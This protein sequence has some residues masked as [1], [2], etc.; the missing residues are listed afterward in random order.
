MIGQMR[1]LLGLCIIALCVA[2]TML[3]VTS[4][5]RARLADAQSEAARLAEQGA[6]LLARLDD[7]KRIED[8]QVVMPQ[9]YLWP[10]QDRAALELTFQQALVGAAEATGLRLVSFGPGRA[11]EGIRTAALGYEV[12]VEGGHE[13]LA[14][15]LMTIEEHDPQLGYLYLWMRQQAGGTDVDGKA[16]VSARL[17]VW[18][19]TDM[20]VETA[21]P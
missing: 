10:G 4:W 15:F 20:P 21:A 11:P 12:E 16:L 9:G 14:R 3:A 8:D 18:G 5:S 17:G 1:Q 13:E 7:A 6:A 19:F 2:V